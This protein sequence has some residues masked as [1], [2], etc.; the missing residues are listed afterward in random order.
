MKIVRKINALV[1]AGIFAHSAWAEPRFEGVI[2][3]SGSEQFLISEENLENGK[4]VRLVSPFLKIGQTYW[5]WV[6]ISYDEKREILA[7]KKN[8]RL[9]EIRIKDSK[10]LDSVEGEGAR[11]IDGK[12]FLGKA[13][14]IADAGNARMK[15]KLEGLKTI[16]KDSERTKSA[17]EASEDNLAVLKTKYGAEGKSGV[18]Y[19][20]LSA[21]IDGLKKRYLQIIQKQLDLERQI[22]LEVK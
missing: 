20:R 1:L 9:L 6:L 11:K 4:S 12:S 5:G 14:V 13:Q 21:R 3:S 8:S 7:V 16:E 17:I 15:V 19:N 18:E 10:I 22:A 2:S